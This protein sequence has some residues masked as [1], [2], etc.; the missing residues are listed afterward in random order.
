MSSNNRE[1][2]ESVNGKAVYL[3]RSH[4]KR[5]WDVWKLL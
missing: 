4:I 2:V 1:E 5:E 3:G